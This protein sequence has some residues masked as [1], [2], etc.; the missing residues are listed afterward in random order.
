M[1]QRRKFSPD[2][3]AVDLMGKKL[4]QKFAY[5]VAAS[6]QQQPFALF[7]EFRKLADVRGVGS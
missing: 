6:S 3:A 7:Q 1:P 2:A 5:I 4:L